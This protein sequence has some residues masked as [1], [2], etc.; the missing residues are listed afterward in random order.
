MKEEQIPT[1]LPDDYVEYHA[2]NLTRPILTY[3]KPLPVLAALAREVLKLRTAIRT[4]MNMRGDHRCYQDDATLYGVL[5]EG[6]V[7]PEQETAV[8]LENCQ[9]YIACRQQGRTYISPQQR[10]EELEALVK[11]WQEAYSKLEATK[12]HV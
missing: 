2:Q 3:V 1:V 5:P 10:I 11:H 9:K 8:T 4:H 6:D 12:N 7:R